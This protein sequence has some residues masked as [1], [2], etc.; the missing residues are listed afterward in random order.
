MLIS[1]DDSECPRILMILHDKPRNGFR[2]FTVDLA[3]FNQLPTKLLDVSRGVVGA[4]VN[5]DRV[6][7]G[8]R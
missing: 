3:G 1:L 4:K 5:Y 8:C 6:D 2:I 7:H